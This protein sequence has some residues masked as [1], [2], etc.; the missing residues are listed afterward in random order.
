[1]VN[2][3]FMTATDTT[4][5]TNNYQDAT[6]RSLRLKPVVTIKESAP[7]STA[8][9]IMREKG[10]DQLPVLAA[11]SSKLVGLV[12]LG[13]LL[14]KLSRGTITAS[15]PVEK[16]FFDFR[17]IK[18]V[19]SDPRLIGSVGEVGEKG[20]SKKTFDEIT[21]DTP[22][23]ALSKFF[24]INSAAVVTER[25]KEGELKPIHV[26]TKVDLLGFLVKSGSLE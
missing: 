1:M 18:E 2:N 21:L 5:K 25:T 12:T 14:S 3:N 7:I 6:I 13:N 11:S 20:T 17:K 16:A 9:D 23:K 19:V 26:V 8:I 4:S 22:L 10:Y 15:S 24:E